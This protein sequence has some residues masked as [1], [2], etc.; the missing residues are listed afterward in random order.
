MSEMELNKGKLIPAGID[1]ENY[2]DED[3]DTLYENGLIFVG[4][5]WYEVDYEI[6][7]SDCYGFRHVS[8]NSDGSIDFIT[9]H[10]NGGGSLGE[11]IENAI[12]N[13]NSWSG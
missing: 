12:E 5:E 8:V 6:K 7:S 2:T 9:Y 11:V 13:G 10:Y 3:F 1:T 4:G